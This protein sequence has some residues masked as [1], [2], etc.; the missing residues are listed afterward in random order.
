MKTDIKRLIT[1]IVSVLFIFAFLPISLSEHG[2]W[3]CQECGRTGETGNYCGGCGCPAPWI[4]EK[5]ESADIDI[6]NSD[7]V[8]ALDTITKVIEPAEAGDAVRCPSHSDARI[9]VSI[10]AQVW[11][12][13]EGNHRFLYG[14]V[15]TCSVCGEE[16]RETG[17]NETQGHVFN[18]GQCIICQYSNKTETKTETP[19]EY[20]RKAGTGSS[21]AKRSPDASDIY[22]GEVEILYGITGDRKLVRCLPDPNS[23]MVIAVDPGNR[24]P[25]YG[26]KQGSN[27]RDWYY[28]W[29]K[30]KNMIGWISSNNAKLC[31][32]EPEKQN[33]P[34][35]RIGTVTIRGVIAD[36]NARIVR[37]LPNPDSLL[38]ERVYD[39][40]KYEC[41]ETAIGTN[42]RTWYKIS[43]NG[44][45][46]WISE[47]LC[48]LE[49]DP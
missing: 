10:Q 42:G 13:D 38:V 3:D 24:Y 4:N 6:P 26:A 33:A 17:Y 34:S 39:G 45:T 8:I 1:F 16:L 19:S 25:C 32:E 47:R 7:E 30:E 2:S 41:Y 14:E 43:V 28:I 48:V 27:Y 40:E 31:Q 5:A 21:Y 18:N 35:G 22:I 36:G 9:S 46:G 44:K 23:N 12:V 20:T 15:Y 11:P 49:Y 37:E 29:I